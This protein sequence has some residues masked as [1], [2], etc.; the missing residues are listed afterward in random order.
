MVKKK[1]QSIEELKEKKETFAQYVHQVKSGE[2]NLTSARIT[3]QDRIAVFK[4]E[5]QDLKGIPYSTLVE[6][7]KDKTG[8]KVSEQSLRQYCQNELGWPKRKKN[9][10]ANTTIE[11]NSENKNEDQEKFNYAE[12]DDNNHSEHALSPESNSWS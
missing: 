8:L 10:K 12:A 7:L 5:L 9:K 1:D 2:I 11:I 4:E 6:I 3:T